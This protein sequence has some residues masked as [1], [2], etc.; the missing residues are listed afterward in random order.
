MMFSTRS[1]GTNS[2]SSQSLMRFRHKLVSS[3]KKK[4]LKILFILR[5]YATFKVKK[6]ESLLYKINTFLKKKQT[7]TCFGLQVEQIFSVSIQY[8][9]FVNFGRDILGSFSLLFSKAPASSCKNIEIISTALHFILHDLKKCVSDFLNLVSNYIYYFCFPFVTSF[10]VDVCN[11]KTLFLT[12]K[13]SA[14]FNLAL[15]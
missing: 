13:A 7:I 6:F 1:R 9:Y 10:F 5:Y 15:Y 8:T 3:Q 2:K 4:L 14:E 11:Q 12:K